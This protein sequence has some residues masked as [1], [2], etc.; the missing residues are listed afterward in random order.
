M[1]NFNNV[2]KMHF[3]NKIIK[4]NEN[5][6]NSSVSNSNSFELLIYQLN[7]YVKEISSQ[8]QMQ[9]NLVNSI[10]NNVN[11]NIINLF[12]N[13]INREIEKEKVKVR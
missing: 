4:N 5:S 3:R 6:T 13:K 8:N 7:N 12:E 10:M 9:F 11:S 2:Y 1:S